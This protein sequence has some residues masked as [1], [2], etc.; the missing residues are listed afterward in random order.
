MLIVYIDIDTLRPDHLGCYGYH[1]NTSPNIDRVASE[2]IRFNQCYVSDAPCLPSRAAL[3]HGRFGIHTGAINHGGTY[4]DPFKEGAGRGFRTTP[5]YWKWMQVLQH[6][7]FHTAS[8]SSF[9]GRHSSWWFLA[10]FNEVYDCGKRGSE[11]ATDVTGHALDFIERNRGRDNWLLHFNI[12][13]PHTPYRVPREYGNPFDSDPISDWVTQEMIDRQRETYGPHSALLPFSDPNPKPTHREVPEIRNLEDY[14]TWIDGYD[15]G[16]RFADDAVGRILEKLEQC[17]LYED[18]AIIISS[19][20]GENQG[21]LNV[22]GDHQT[23]DLITNRVPMILKWPGLNPATG[24][25]RKVTDDALHYQFDVAATIVELVGQQIPDKWDAVSFK[26]ALIT[27]GEEGRKYLVASQAAWSC[28]RAVIFG[29]HILI[30]T[31]MDGLKDLPEIMLYDRVQ[32]PHELVDIAAM[33]PD[34]VNEG[35]ALLERW[36]T[37]QLMSSD[38]KEDPMM[39]IIEEGGPFHTRGKLPDY[40]EYFKRIGRPEISEL[41]LKKYGENPA[42]NP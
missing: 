35:L 6:A 4:A 32:D 13:D 23:A 33:K 2:A 27:G 9:A 7:G 5:P 16:I 14:K 10:G 19:D 18:T 8:I 12:W 41:M 40:A 31:Y 42:Y 11:I 37:E 36:I 26:E 1:R 34:K 29:D 30:R 22:Y 15:V 25:K 3:H 20:H 24:S 17:G 39:K 28:Q 21:E 38:T